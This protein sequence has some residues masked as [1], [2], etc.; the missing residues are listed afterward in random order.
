MKDEVNY[1]S[2]TNPQFLKIADLKKVL[3]K[4]EKEVDG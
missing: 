2:K 4:L 1:S 3:K